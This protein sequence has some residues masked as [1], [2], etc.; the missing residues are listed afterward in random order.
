MTAL[1]R[2]TPG[3]AAAYR[4]AVEEA[5]GREVMAVA[6]IDEDGKIAGITIAARGSREAVPALKPYMEAGDA[7][8]HNHPS[9]RLSPSQADLSIASALGE[10]GIGFYITNNRVDE[11]YVVAEP[12]GRKTVTALDP[13]NLRRYLE[14]ESPLGREDFYEYRES[15]VAMMDL[16]AEAF[17]RRA[18]CVAEAGTGVGKSLAY[19][20]P[21]VVWA[22]ANDERVVIST[23]TIN[24]QQQLIEKDLPLV[25]RIL[26]RQFKAVLVKGRGNYL[27]RRRLQEA[28]D[29]NS[30]FREED[31]DLDAIREWAET[32]EEGSRSDLSFYPPAET[33]QKVCSEADICLG[34]NCP[35]RE[36]CFIIR[37]RREAAS[38]NILVAN[39]HLLFSD[40]EARISGA[41]FEGTAVLPPFKHLV[42]D[43]AHNIE[44][45]ATSFFSGEI[46]RFFLY[47]QLTRLWNRR[48]GR[49]GGQIIRLQALAGGD[50]GDDGIPSAVEAVKEKW[51]Q[52][53]QQGLLFL[54]ERQT[55]RLTPE[56]AEGFS[57]LM[58]R[59]LG[60]LQ[61][62]LM[63]LLERTAAMMERVGDE[64]REEPVYLEVRSL[65]RRL[66]SFGA[67]FASFQVWDEKP[68]RV[69]W[70]ERSRS[71]KGESF[72]KM[73][74]T[75]L[76]IT[77]MMR[78]AVFEPLET[79]V[80]ASATLSIGGNFSF[81]KKRI[82]LHGYDFR[83]VLEETFSSPF[84][85]PGQ[86][87]LGIPMDGPEPNS[88][89]FQPFLEGMVERLIALTDGRALVLF[90]S[91]TML[92][93]TFDSLET[94]L[95]EAGITALRQGS[96]ERW[97][98]LERF[99]EDESS[100]LFATSS[101]WEGVDAPGNTL[102]SV[103]IC[104][105]P[106][107]V[108]SDPVISARMELIE[109]RG[110]NSFRDYFLPEA[111]I[112]FKQGFGRLMRRH[113]D[114]GI[115]TVLDPRIV[116]KGYGRIFLKSIPPATVLVKPAEQLLADYERFL[117]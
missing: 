22:V 83:E 102:K 70:L 85:Y 40:L 28:L 49:N 96:D 3:A 93:R 38:A 112:R 48:R 2:M 52:L 66:E 89:D 47:K 39:H 110:G 29:E 37:A 60:E 17:N 98:L 115:V 8:I 106:F 20:I 97:R 16:V 87:L 7:V 32:T 42:F 91:Y 4:S 90:T 61:T 6:A 35:Q 11:I 53:E 117:Y 50:A 73:T 75:P 12:A 63:G 31:D 86:V 113:S 64:D 80:S 10:Q 43:E 1:Q 13:A 14:P 100:V 72:L 54:E 101:F 41:G 99:K 81:W 36:K 84:D 76:D 55:V 19:L 24:L 62:A 107:M 21:A 5:G 111:V 77:P 88:G 33:W 116:K 92:K 109:R 58:G 18:L 94:P 68:E 104:R 108:P 65:T 78:E 46:N 105:L 69:F 82:G 114:S 30:L 15:Q 26:E 79:V 103:I 59:G 45:S 34:L 57:S 51:E 27:C 56:S 67:L 25:K 23:A 44:K 74:S 95:R 9:G 71:Y